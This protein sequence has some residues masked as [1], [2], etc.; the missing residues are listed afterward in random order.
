MLRR[1]GHARLLY[2]NDDGVGANEGGEG[3]WRVLL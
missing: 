3:G 1:C 2:V